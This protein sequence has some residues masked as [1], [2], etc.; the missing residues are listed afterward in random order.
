MWQELATFW[1]GDRHQKETVGCDGNQATKG[2][3]RLPQDATTNG[4]GGECDAGQQQSFVR[5]FML[6]WSCSSTAIE[7][8]QY[9]RMRHAVMML[10][11][12]EH[13]HLPAFHLLLLLLFVIIINH[14]TASSIGNVFYAFLLLILG[15]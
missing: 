4:V 7:K 12:R 13:D 8:E 6:L 15:S 9:W 10:A 3:T 11:V 14:S 5:S 2:G 1:L